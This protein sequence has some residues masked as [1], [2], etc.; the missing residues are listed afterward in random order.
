M[1]LGEDVVSSASVLVVPTRDDEGRMV[2]TPLATAF[3]VEFPAQFGRKWYY[4][5]TAAHVVAGRTDVSVRLRVRG[6]STRDEPVHTWERHPSEDVA[7]APIREATLA[8]ID[9]AAIPVDLFADSE[10]A[11]RTLLGDDIYFLG[12]LRGL[13]HMA[14]EGVTM[15]RSGTLG[16]MDQQRVPIK[17]SATSF[18]YFTSHLI[19]CRAYQ[20]MSGAPCFVSFLDKWP[21]PSGGGATIGDRIMLLGVV[22]AHF[23]EQ[24]KAQ[25]TGGLFGVEIK[26][27]IHTGVGVVSPVRFLRELLFDSEELIRLRTEGDRE[28]L[29]EA[30]RAALAAAASSDS[31]A[32]ESEFDAFE[33]LARK[34]VQVPK[35]EIDEQRDKGVEPERE[36]EDE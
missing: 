12:V 31:I 14:V 26:V 27:P 16:R 36:M 35:S 32:T 25:S 20:G 8:G 17:E 22:S 23:D 6:R 29:G 11:R 33:D 2:P 3:L 34:I 13:P 1:T 15:V 28:A 5:V 30:R 9:C 21:D 19:D 4:L 7:V 24:M 18:R 10:G